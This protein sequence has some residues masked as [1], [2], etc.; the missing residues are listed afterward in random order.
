MSKSLRKNLLIIFSV[1]LV[2][3]SSLFCVGL[4]KVNASSGLSITMNKGALIRL[5][6][7][8]GLRFRATLNNYNP[9][10]DLEYGV[11][12]VP[13]DYLTTYNIEDNYVNELENLV[14]QNKIPAYINGKA[15]PVEIK[16]EWVIQ[17]SIVSIREENYDR[18]FV[19]IGYILD[20]QGYH[21][22]TP[23]DNERSITYIASVALNELNY[24]TELD[25]D[26]KA[27][28]E[29]NRD[30]LENFVIQGVANVTDK[31]QTQISGETTLNAGDVCYFGIDGANDIK[32]DWRWESED[33]NIAMV[34]ST[35]EVEAL[36]VGAA[37]IT[38]KS[39]GLY[40]NNLTVNVHGE[41]FEFGAYW[42]KGSAGKLWTDESGNLIT[43]V[44]EGNKV[45][46]RKLREYKDAGL[47][48]YIPQLSASYVA[49]SSTWE[50]CD[51]QR[52]MNLC[53]QVG[54]KVLVHDEQL[55]C[56]CDPERYDLADYFY[57]DGVYSEDKLVKWIKNATPY[58]NHAAFYG[59][60]LYDEPSAGMADT[61]GKVYSALR[62]AYPEAYVHVCLLPE[63][64]VGATQEENQIYYD[65]LLDEAGLEYLMY[66]QY[67]MWA[68][69][70]MGSY[71]YNLKW[72]AE[73]CKE[74]GIDLKLATQTYKGDENFRNLDEDD[75]YWINNML[76]G[77]GVKNAYYYTYLTAG[78]NVDG[79]TFINNAGEKTDTYN[80][81]QKITAEMQLLA[82]MALQYD[83]NA[84]AI[85]VGNE[86][87]GM[88]GH[89]KKFVSDKLTKITG[90]TVNNERTLIT[91]LKKATGYMYMVQNVGDPNCTC[92]YAGVQEVKLT[93]S[94]DVKEF[95]IFE[96][97]K[98]EKIEING[99]TYELNLNAGRAAYI[100]LTVDENSVSIKD[101]LENG[102]VW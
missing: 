88:H 84:S 93:F 34:S 78:N 32:L 67:P 43:D 80:A 14:A 29:E 17:H 26:S 101:L 18:D 97:G 81:M 47:K 100:F 96:G 68:T 3:V 2:L 74:R 72:R 31:F 56:F 52:V 76:V 83:Y 44:E 71:I 65:T 22:A 66:D 87:T 60:D 91:E 49:G 10:A 70:I 1:V 21:Y 45:A 46:L 89:Y 64:H 82:P 59:F 24:N 51:L 73:I 90:A 37:K 19:G 95:I 94:S 61:L 20:E 92:Q 36:S 27:V 25:E 7:Q 85:Y 15:K 53:E 86:G 16:G 6:D 30:L 102:E 11:I 12:I 79:Y 63:D 77:F 35:G 38:A 75:L 50:G 9:D 58:A 55:T 62:K 33:T 42:G 54:L 98:Y 4:T 5:T 41:Q 69:T 40:E 48:V 28:Y 8:S 23:N 57:Q 99:N 13:K 39:C